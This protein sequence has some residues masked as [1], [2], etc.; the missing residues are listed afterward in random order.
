MSPIVRN[1]SVVLIVG[2]LAFLAGLFVNR[3]SEETNYPIGMDETADSG[4]SFNDYGI[5]VIP[6][7]DSCE[8]NFTADD[9]EFIDSLEVFRFD[10]VIRGLFSTKFM[11]INH[12]GSP[13]NV[14]NFYHEKMKYCLPDV[15]LV[16]DREV[17]LQEAIS[18]VIDNGELYNIQ[19]EMPVYIKVFGGEITAFYKK[20]N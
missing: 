8:L 10:R 14:L 4:L 1:I 3:S 18:E 11:V 5:L 15:E 20:E 19:L 7:L 16:F 17:N 6:L 2:V 9:S 12:R 13:A